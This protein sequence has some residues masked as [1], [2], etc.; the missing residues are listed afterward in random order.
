MQIAATNYVLKDVNGS[1]EESQ[2]AENSTQFYTEELASGQVA[3]V[4]RKPEKHF[5]PCFI[6]YSPLF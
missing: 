2:W 3:Y 6:F 1:A 5:G 4:Q